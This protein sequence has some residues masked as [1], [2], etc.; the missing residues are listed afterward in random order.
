MSSGYTSRLGPH[1]E[2]MVAQKHAVGYPYKESER[3]LH[4]FD[5]FCAAGF[6]GA[7][8]ITPEIGNAWAVIKP[9]EKTNSF[10]DRLAPVRELARY[11][12]LA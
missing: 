6:P 4:V 3:I 7:E 8:T 1:I 5:H 2:Q 11:M 12:N 9:T 10:L